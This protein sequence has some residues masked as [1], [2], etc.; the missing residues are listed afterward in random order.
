MMKLIGPVTH[1]EAHWS[2]NSSWSWLVSLSSGSWLV[3]WGES[4]WE[5]Q[6]SFSSFNSVSYVLC[7][8]IDIH[9]QSSLALFLFSL[10]ISHMD[11]TFV[12]QVGIT[13]QAKSRIVNTTCYIVVFWNTQKCKSFVLINWIHDLIISSMVDSWPH[14]FIHSK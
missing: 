12:Y 5:Y 7:Y 2:C 3:S 1:D 10:N 4:H 13:K 14:H 6:L 11:E 8:K 9:E